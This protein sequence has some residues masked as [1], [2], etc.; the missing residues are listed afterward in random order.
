MTDVSATPQ[1]VA[2]RLGADER[3][4]GW[5]VFAAALL[6]TLGTLNV[7]DGIAAIGNSQFFA[8][9]AHYLVGDLG[10]WGWILAAIGV[11]QGIT[12]FAIARGSEVARW[13]GT[14]FALANALAQ[15]LFMQAYPLWSL[16]IFAVDLLVV[17]A[18]VV[19][20]TPRL[21]PA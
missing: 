9:H 10:S 1:A 3:G 11:C 2:L 8:R 20:G 13:A 17:Y 16:A 15:L 18:L 5:I 4:R 14:G 21:R 19:Y 6:M 12:G 7:I